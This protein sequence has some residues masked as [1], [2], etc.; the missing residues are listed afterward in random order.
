MSLFKRGTTWWVRFTAPNGQQV[1][2]SAQTANK[3]QAQEFHDQLKSEC[4]RVAKLGETPRYKWQQAVER[5][6][7]EKNGEKVTLHDDRNHLRWLHAH[8]YDLYLDEINRDTIERITLAR[9]KEG[10]SHATVNRLL[11]AL[12]AILR[13][14]EHD[15]EWLN[16]APHIR[17]LPEPKKRVRW[18]TQQETQRLLSVLPEYLAEMVRFSLGTGLRESNVTDLQWSQVDLQRQC[19][20]IHPD[21]AKARKA[22]PV[23]LNSDALAVIERQRG[24]HPV[25]VFSYQGKKVR[26]GNNHTWRKALKQA[27]IENFRWHDLRH[28]WASWH[29]QRGTPL[30]VLQELGGWS[31][32]E[33]VQRYA[34]LSADHLKA[35]ADR[36]AEPLGRLAQN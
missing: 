10:V 12:R 7:L 4:W 2:R 26:N 29:I 8:L 33:M 32:P 1:R 21:Q 22:I 5:W 20:W 17:L 6:L 31:G 24:K 13:R 16:K 27:G 35:Y 14:A 25:Y 23:P 15:W 18:L 9:L 11:A 3:Q 19:A 30:H 36:L 34:H 28:T